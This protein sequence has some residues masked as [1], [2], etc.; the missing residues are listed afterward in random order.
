[1]GKLTRHLLEFGP[2][3][4]DPDQRLLLRDQQPVPI[5]PKAFDLLL[6][7]T[8][9]RGEV[10]LKD[11][12]MKML[13]PDT[14]VEESNLGQHVFQLRK[15]LGERPQDHTYIITVPGRGYRFAQNVR[16]VMAQEEIEDKHLEEVSED[17]IVAASRSL[18][19][20]VIDRDSKK[21]LRL[22]AA[23]STALIAVAV[24]AGLYF[25]S[26]RKPKLTEK[27]TIV[28]ADFDNKAGDSVFD[29][30]LRQGLAA[31]LAQSPFL[32]L[33]A[34]QSAAHTLSLMGQ[35]KDA[36]LRNDLAHEVCQR[37]QS[38]AVLDPSIAQIGTRYLL[39]L[40]AINCSSGDTLASVEAEASD[41]NHVLDALG[42]M[43]SEIRRK[44]GES[45]AS[46]RKYN[47]E[48]EDVS[49]PSLD[50]LKIYTLAHQ[51]QLTDRALESVSLYK[52]ALE[53]DPNFAM[54]YLGLGA[55]YFN[56]DETSQAAEDVQKAY[57]L[58]QRV[59][60]REKLQ[61]EQMYYAA[62]TRDFEEDR[63]SALLTIA[64]YPRGWGIINNLG[65]IYGYLGDHDN[66][67]AA[68]QK[69]LE[70][71]PGNLQILTN[72]LICYLHSDRLDDAAAL[73]REVRTENFETPFFH[74]TLYQVAFLRHDADAMDREAAEVLGKPGFDDLI[75]YYQ[76][77]TAA[78]AGQFARARQ[79][80]RRAAD[81]TVRSGQKETTAEYE[82]EAAVR[83]ALVGNLA[84]AKGQARNA[85]ALSDGRDAAAMSA[86]ALAMTRDPL[87]LRV[88]EDLSKRFPDDTALKYN[89]LPSARAAAALQNGESSKAL[90]NLAV[91][92]QYELGETVQE[93]TF[94]LYPV[95]LRGQAYL[96]ARQ[97]AAAVAE[98]RKI[99]DHPGLVQN[100]P[101]GA[102]AQLGLGR[103]YA[104]AGDMSKAKTAYQ[105]FFVLW[106]GADPDIPI[107]KQ[108]KAEYAK[109]N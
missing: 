46:V 85:L 97:G 78:Y 43:A 84:L 77:D 108:A 21:D 82:A 20:M 30:T 66:A 35:S 104:L 29:G 33:L 87:G 32:N 81:S 47:A 83:E 31:Q 15:A 2:F 90:T 58:R 45:L 64:I 38:V 27:D 71:A 1:M 106:K 16:E 7:L 52:K 12:L 25:Q 107:L 48:P 50:A 42:K 102:L 59:S 70:L 60:E 76:S 99:L 3:Q 109:L 98:F 23:V 4:V 36:P 54:A 68:V 69:A 26:Q 51:A 93:A 14:F 57:E 67:L 17:Q 88:S 65:V 11:D 72:L 28:L 89:L 24:A 18:T 19:R 74:S 80:T 96:A 40:K 22:W 41:K 6:A 79:L 105:D 10:A 101:I 8:Q 55:N 5:S 53:L 56:L 86:I 37:T 61:I 62:V 91:S 9:R 100:E 34:D 39:T 73:A 75:S 95:Y 92:S 94:V 44:L 103:A 63:K 13:W 49:T